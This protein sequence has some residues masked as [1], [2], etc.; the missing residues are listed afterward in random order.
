MRK[1]DARHPPR[2]PVFSVRR[3]GDLEFLLTYPRKLAGHRVELKLITPSG[4]LYQ[5]ISA[6]L[7]APPHRRASAELSLRLPVSGTLIERSALYGRWRAETLVDHR[8]AVCRR[9]LRFTLNR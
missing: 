1:A 2:K 6:T 8:L 3:V 9:P 4:H 5:T 7:E